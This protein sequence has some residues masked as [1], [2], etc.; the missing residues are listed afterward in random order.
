MALFVSTERIKGDILRLVPKANQLKVRIL[1]A[2]LEKA[3]KDRDVF[4]IRRDQ[5][6]LGHLRGPE[7]IVNRLTTVLMRGK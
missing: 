4:L 5:K 1:L 6:N 3:N 7:A 2:E